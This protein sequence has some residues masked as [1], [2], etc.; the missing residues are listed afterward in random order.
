MSFILAVLNIQILLP[1]RYFNITR[2]CWKGIVLFSKKQTREAC[3][4]N[5][6]REFPALFGTN[7]EKVWT[8]EAV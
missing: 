6:T 1:E 3:E 5:C 4:L 2:M 8:S 7:M